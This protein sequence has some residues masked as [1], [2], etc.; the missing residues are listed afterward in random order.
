MKHLRI[1]QDSIVQKSFIIFLQLRFPSA[2]I[3]QLP[4]LGGIKL[5]QVILRDFP[6]KI[7]PH[8]WVGNINDPMKMALKHVEEEW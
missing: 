1:Q 3:I 8:V 6:P 5:D 4:I 7:V 2:G